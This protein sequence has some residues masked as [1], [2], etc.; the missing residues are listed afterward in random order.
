M[1]HWYFSLLYLHAP[2][3]CLTGVECIFAEWMNIS[4]SAMLSHYVPYTCVF[5]SFYIL[6]ILYPMNGTASTKKHNIETLI[7]LHQPLPLIGIYIFLSH[8][9]LLLTATAFVQAHAS[10]TEIPTWFYSSLL[11][12]SLPSSFLNLL[13]ILFSRLNTFEVTN[14]KLEWYRG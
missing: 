6:Y 10:G 14:G 7:H 9:P 8:P 12:L 4:N 3:Q 2:P 1:C 5:S 11:E 13:P